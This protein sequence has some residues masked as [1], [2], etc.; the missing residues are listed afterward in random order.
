MFYSIFANA[1]A[2]K[3]DDSTSV[4]STHSAAVV[5]QDEKEVY[6]VVYCSEM[7]VVIS[8]TFDAKAL[9]SAKYSLSQLRANFN[10]DRVLKDVLT[11]SVELLRDSE[12]VHYIDEK[13]S[14][15]LY[16]SDLEIE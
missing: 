16:A 10:C 1:T 6:S 3:L 2:R 8:E 4:Y 9:E 7:Q 14:L 12:Q 11:L 5:Y 13:Y 15:C